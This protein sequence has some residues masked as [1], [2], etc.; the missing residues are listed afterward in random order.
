MSLIENIAE[1]SIWGDGFGS[2]STIPEPDWRVSAQESSLDTTTSLNT[3]ATGRNRTGGY[4]EGMNLGIF[5]EQK[6]YKDRLNSITGEV[7]YSYSGGYNSRYDYDKDNGI[8]GYDIVGIKG[9]QVEQMRESIR[10]YVD[11][12]Q[13]TMEDALNQNANETKKAIRGEDAI[14]AVNEYV[15]KVKTY[16][17][18][19]IS[20]MLIFSDKL[21]DVGNA[22]NKAQQTMASD[23]KVTTG[24]FSEGKTYSENVQY[25]GDTSSTASSTVLGGG[26]SGPKFQVTY[27]Q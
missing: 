7:R 8:A 22:W 20:S 18:N 11:R 21:A 27:D 4:S 15:A 14:A 2:N 16:C 17:Q 12:V 1:G 9:S 23:V 3:L 24:S 5:G 6:S 26:A 10:A 13:R 19:I 25:T